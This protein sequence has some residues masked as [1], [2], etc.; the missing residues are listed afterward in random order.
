MPALA[1]AFALWP[2]PRP[3]LASSSSASLSDETSACDG[4]MSAL[5]VCTGLPPVPL[6]V[7]VAVDALS[8]AMPNVNRVDFRLESAAAAGGEG[9]C[10]GAGAAD[11]ASADSGR[12]LKRGEPVTR[13]IR[14]DACRGGEETV[15]VVVVLTVVAM[16]LVTVVVVDPLALV[17]V[18]A[19]A[20]VVT[21]AVAVVADADVIQ[22]KT[23]AQK[24][25]LR[26]LF[27]YF[28]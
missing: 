5:V 19:V 6:C 10:C 2:S 25:M 12:L 3:P 18:V 20:A 9:C 22:V 1:D 8:F 24:Y 21:V 11:R 14:I 23:E 17:T 4:T 13:S 26:T 16:V 27:S 28:S 7:A 15:V